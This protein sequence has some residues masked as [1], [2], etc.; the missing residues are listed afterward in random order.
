[1]PV[2]SIYCSMITLESRL[3]SWSCSITAATRIHIAASSVPISSTH[4]TLIDMPSQNCLTRSILLTPTVQMY[5]VYQRTS[6]YA[7]PKFELAG[8]IFKAKS[9]TAAED[10]PQIRGL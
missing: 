5:T 8:T 7:I 10:T 9:R 6:R 1:M 3:K 4:F 2:M